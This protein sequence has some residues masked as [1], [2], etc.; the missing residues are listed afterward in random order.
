[1]D[2]KVETNS[3]H[4]NDIKNDFLDPKNPK[5]HIL[6]STVGHTIEKIIFNMADDGHFGFGPLTELAHT[7]AR[8]IEAKILN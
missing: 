8:G 5:N 1:L 2:L 4:Q 3:N 6:H 7:F